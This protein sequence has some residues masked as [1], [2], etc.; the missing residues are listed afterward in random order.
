MT[1][2]STGRTG[3]I[4]SINLSR[5]KGQ[6]KIPVAEAEIVAG[7]GLREDAHRGFAHRQISLL[8]AESIE[9][10]KKRILGKP[11][12]PLEPGVF[13]ENLTTRNID[14]KSL[15]IGDRLLIQG[16]IRLE[17]SQIGKECH[18]RCAIFKL[19]GDC[20]MPTEG[21]FCEVL[22]SG[23]IRVGDPIEKS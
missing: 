11:P 14:L 13:A 20:I 9:E 1:A 12:I 8:A 4:L 7:E 17:V 10:Q 22:D 3:K 18:T 21:I 16:R 19:A 6:I 5:K 15:K 2:P 23:T